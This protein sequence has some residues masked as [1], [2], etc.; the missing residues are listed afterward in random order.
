MVVRLS[1]KYAEG[2]YTLE[3]RADASTWLADPLGAL[4]KV[5]T[6]PEKRRKVVMAM[7][8]ARLLLVLSS[9]LLS[10]T[11]ARK[12]QADNSMVLDAHEVIFLSGPGKA[13]ITGSLRSF[14]CGMFHIPF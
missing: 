5:G 10:C 9:L 7:N 6:N 1:K 12:L 2:E 11:A 3:Y 13:A 4:V 14:F 8:L